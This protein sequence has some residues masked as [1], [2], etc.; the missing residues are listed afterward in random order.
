[1]NAKRKGTMRELRLSDIYSDQSGVYFLFI[2][3]CL[4]IEMYSFLIAGFVFSRAVFA[5]NRNYNRLTSVPALLVFY[6]SHQHT[7]KVNV[8]LIVN[9][10]F[11]LNN[12]VFV[13]N[14]RAV[15]IAT[16][17]YLRPL[18]LFCF[19]LFIVDFAEYTSPYVMQN[20]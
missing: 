8:Q 10:W 9:I 2:D 18:P 19:Y 3:V 20:V 5:S 12:S 13:C 6:L 14:L 4:A 7:R 16:T 11:P 1:M 15:P 17:L